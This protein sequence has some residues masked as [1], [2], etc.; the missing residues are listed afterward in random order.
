MDTIKELTATLII[1]PFNF[2]TISTR[3]FEL[4][5]DERYREA[6]PFSLMIVIIGL[7][8]IIILF[9]LDDENKK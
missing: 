5:S 2:E 3:I 8:S 9:K 6:A 7:I 1:R 4:V